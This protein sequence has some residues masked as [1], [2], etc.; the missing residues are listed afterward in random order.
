MATIRVHT[1]QNVTLEYD[2]ASVGDRILA[3]LVDY[4]LYGVWFIFCGVVGSQL[5]LN[6]GNVGVFLMLLPTLFYFLACEVFFNGQT[7]G[8]KARHLRV[9]RLDGT[10]PGLGDYVLRWL[11]RPIEVIAFWGAPALITILLNGKGQRLGDL[12]AGTTVVSLLR[13]ADRETTMTTD[14]MALENYQPVFPQVAALSD[15][16]VALIRKL[17]YQAS[18]KENYL[19]LSELANKVKAL[20]GIQTDL[21]DGPFL[22][23]VLRDHASL[24]LRSTE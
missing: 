8:K 10:R 1:A 17:V 3:T 12:A 22:Q 6:M 7:L 2:I 19:L 18:Q 16:D 11:L 23:T 15:H 20:T 4:V 21:R 24:T 14:L 9:M 13:R 5:G